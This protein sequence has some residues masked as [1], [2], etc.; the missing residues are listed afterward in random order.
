MKKY[1]LVIENKALQTNFSTS[2][3][4]RL[5]E[6]FSLDKEN[7]I[8]MIKI[9]CVKCAMT[10]YA[11]IESAL[12]YENECLDTYALSISYQCISDIDI[13][14]ENSQLAHAL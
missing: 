14:A 4:L 1:N 9:H 5:V 7:K 11:M 6:K 10:Q 12:V 3:M 13:C 2:H 8:R